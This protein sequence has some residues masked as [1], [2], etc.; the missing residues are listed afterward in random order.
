ML[1]FP[2]RGHSFS[3]QKDIPVLLAVR[4]HYL[5]IQQAPDLR[6]IAKVFKVDVRETSAKAEREL[7]AKV[8]EELARAKKSEA[9]RKKSVATGT[10]SQT[11]T[12]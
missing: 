12:P 10:K 8:R 11:T 4:L 1:A 3:T 2:D 9:R 5:D 6:D 7:A